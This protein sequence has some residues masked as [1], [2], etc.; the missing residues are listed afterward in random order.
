MK[1]IVLAIVILLVIGLFAGHALLTR[2]FAQLMGN[3]ASQVAAHGRLTWDGVS[4]SHTGK[5]TVQRVQFQPHGSRDRI[6]LDELV[7]DTGSLGGLISFGRMLDHNLLPSS[8]RV[9]ARSLDI[10]VNRLIS[11]WLGDFNPGLPFA[12]AGCGDF[13][14]FQFYYLGDI[15]LI[16]LT[17]NVLLDYQIVNQ[18]NELDLNIV[19][20]A[21][22][23]SE[24]TT[25]LRLALDEPSRS[26]REVPQSLARTR[27][28]TGA[29]T[30][31]DLG[32]YPRLMAMCAEH[33]GNEPDDYIHHHINAWIRNWAELGLEPGRL[34]LV[35]YR[36]FLHQPGT[37]TLTTEPEPAPVLETF[38]RSRF[39]RMIGEIPVRFSVEEGT[40]VDLVFRETDIPVQTDIAPLT[41]PDDDSAPVVT[42]E[43]DDGVVVGR[44]PQWRS[45]NVTEI[46]NYIDHS[47]SILTVDDTRF[48][49]RILEVEGDDVYL[50]IQS[51]TG[52]L[53]RPIPIRSIEEIRIRE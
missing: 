37:V 24:S 18:G 38:S 16:S 29:H 45:I 2:Q 26:I 13:D 52:I 9:T 36:H 4:I 27:L 20:S 10:P 46:G 42:S 8:L 30:F 35:A 5:A 21:S 17:A 41:D 53:M 11:D 48:R 22:Q 7:V 19:I 15:G 49:G 33:T 14:P 3:F 28:L 47:A 6:T 32:F 43:A 51:R 39:T 34:P 12:S 50:S 44:G 25:R 23:L 40:P 31:T 1:R